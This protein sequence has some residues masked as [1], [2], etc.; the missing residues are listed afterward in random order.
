MKLL[1][2][3]WK[4]V[5]RDPRSNALLAQLP[6]EVLA[7]W[8]P[9]LQWVALEADEW[10]YETGQ[11]VRHVYFPVDSVVSLVNVSSDDRSA[12]LA[13]VGFEGLVGLPAL[14]SG[15]TV[16]VGALTQAEGTA[17][18]LEGRLLVDAFDNDA[19]VR[20]VIL[21]FM[22]VFVAQIGQTALCNR[23]HT[24]DQQ[25]CT[26]LLRMMDRKGVDRLELTH[27]ALGTLLGVRRET[28]TQAAGRL[29]QRGLLEYHRGR[30]HVLDRVR[31]ERDACPCYTVVQRVYRNYYG[32]QPPAAPGTGPVA[33]PR[34][35][36]EPLVT[37]SRH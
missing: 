28:I 9:H 34:P 25:L 11:P 15:Y 27:E 33:D 13:M 16:N 4:G 22:Q 35:T 5:V 14:M 26:I 23:H 29:Q 24:P 8:A 20:E 18:Q 7:A 31:L 30:I 19:R 1:E 3:G 21:R 12:L 36:P 32:A 2:A 6:Q 17:L 37:P 10:L